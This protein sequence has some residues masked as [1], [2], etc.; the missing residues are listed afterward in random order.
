MEATDQIKGRN[1]LIKQRA[2]L[3]L[4][5]LSLIEEKKEYALQY[6]Q[7]LTDMFQAFG[8]QPS[9]SEIY[10]SLHELSQDGILKR[11]KKIKGDPKADF[12][13]VV[14]YQFTEIGYEKAK[15]YKSLVRADLDRCIGLLQ[16]AVRD[17][18]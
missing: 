11:I 15:Q 2:F 3:K 10:K 14:L 18:F 8:Y 17:N 7:T 16:K 9:R 12:Q 1:Y 5:L 6:F 13:E 4:Y